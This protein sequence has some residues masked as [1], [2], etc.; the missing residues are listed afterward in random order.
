MIESQA[1]N[2]EN[3]DEGEPITFNPTEWRFFV[4]QLNDMISIGG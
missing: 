3:V 4:S 1:L 2:L